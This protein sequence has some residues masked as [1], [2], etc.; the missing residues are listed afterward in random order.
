LISSSGVQGNNNNLAVSHRHICHYKLNYLKTVCR[1]A[2]VRKWLSYAW[3][4]R[5][6]CQKYPDVSKG[7]CVKD[8]PVAFNKHWVHETSCSYLSLTVVPTNICMTQTASARQ[9]IG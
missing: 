6:R 9:S 2:S 1:H 4:Q 3:V 5:E 8:D 7:I